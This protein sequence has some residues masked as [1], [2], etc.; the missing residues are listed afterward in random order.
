MEEVVPEVT[1]QLDNFRQTEIDL[2]AIR[3]LH[4]LTYD[5]LNINHLKKEELNMI[6]DLLKMRSVGT[7]SMMA[8]LILKRAANIKF[9]DEVCN[10]YSNRFIIQQM[11]L[12]CS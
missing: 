10:S 12:V 5:R 4:T 2:K 3:K 6:C 8:N 11:Q 7:K 9:E 1:E